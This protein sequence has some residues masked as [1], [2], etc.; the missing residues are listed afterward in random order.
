MTR[1]WME[2]YV[3]LPFKDFGR[4][5]AGVDCWG[6]VR[7]VLAHECGITVPSYGEISAEDLSGVAKEVAGESSREP[8]HPTVHA[9]AFDV[10]VMHRRRAPV[11][12][13]IMADVTHVLHI[14][15][16]TNV[17]LI[18]VTHPSVSF[19]S[20]AYFRHRDLLDVAA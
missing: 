16:A 7:L 19:R 4:D 11:H 13:G 3:G 17:V 18:E 5:F 14:E 15:R 9:R 2:K 10:A 12:V 6:L 1:P 20:I 8:W